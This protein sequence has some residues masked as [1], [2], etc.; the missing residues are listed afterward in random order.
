MSE[1]DKLHAAMLE[2]DAK[3]DFELKKDEQDEAAIK[4]AESDLADARESLRLELMALD[5]PPAPLL[6]RALLKDY[7]EAAWHGHKLEGAAAE[8]NA[9]L[10][11][12][13]LAQETRVPLA[14]FLPDQERVQFA[15]VVADVRASGVAERNN[16]AIIEQIWPDNLLPQIGIGM[17]NVPTGEQ[18]LR[19]SDWISN[20]AV[21]VVAPNT[22]K[23]TVDFDLSNVPVNLSRMTGGMIITVESLLTVN[24]LRDVMTRA[25]AAA[26]MS[27]I[28]FEVMHGAGDQNMAKGLFNFIDVFDNV[29]ANPATATTYAEA[30]KIAGDIVDQL[31]FRRGE[32]GKTLV[33]GN[34]TGSFLTTIKDTAASRQF[35]NAYK[36]LEADFRVVEGAAGQTPAQVDATNTV[37]AHQVALAIGRRALE[38]G[39]IFVPVW[40]SVGLTADGGG[41]NARHGRMGFQTDFY[42]GLGYAMASGTPGTD[43]VIPGIKGLTFHTSAKTA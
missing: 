2:A 20:S 15:D 18:N 42:V 35:R 24:G 36:M 30:D 17:T 25:L 32:A 6:E 1:R 4:L 9:Q 7:V 29:T 21:G 43:Q 3:L 5:T 37:G 23:D 26:M 19:W 22:R 34:K 10:D 33:I 14:M 12:K 11:I 40:S 41:D 28:D 39:L 38:A 13:P 27:R 31:W 16:R 8:L